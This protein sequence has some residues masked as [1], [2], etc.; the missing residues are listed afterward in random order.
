MCVCGT[1]CDYETQF[2]SKVL[3]HSGGLY[4]GN[5]SL[6]GSSVN[7]VKTVQENPAFLLLL[8]LFLTQA[9]LFPQRINNTETDRQT[10]RQTEPDKE[11]KHL[12]NKNKKLLTGRSSCNQIHPKQAIV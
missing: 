11:R 10:G 4:N 7:K 8:L 1:G 12:K 5:F 9:S 2:L 6:S 3:L